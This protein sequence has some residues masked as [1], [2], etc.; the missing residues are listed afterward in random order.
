[1]RIHVTMYRRKVELGPTADIMDDKARSPSSPSPSRQSRLF[2]FKRRVWLILVTFAALFYFFFPSNYAYQPY[3]Q[4]RYTVP[5]E[6][7]PTNYL[8]NLTT[9][10]HKPAPFAFCP[11]Y[12]PGDVL[13]LKYGAYR[14]AK[15]KIFEGTGTRIQRVLNKAMSGLPVTISVLGGS[16]MACTR[17]CPS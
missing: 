2:V 12:G 10:S 8:V 15:T 9:G 11:V 16:G 4:H 13:A 5:H 3:P 7:H 1:M 14:L 6:L 17:L